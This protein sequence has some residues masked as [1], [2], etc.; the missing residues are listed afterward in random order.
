MGRE[1]GCES[2]KGFD[3]V[4]NE[5]N[6]I[7]EDLGELCEKMMKVNRMKLRM[8]FEV[9]QGAAAA[10]VVG[11]MVGIDLVVKFRLECLDPT[12]H[13]LVLSLLLLHLGKLLEEGV[14]TL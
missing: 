4:R 2:W 8:R 9:V 1:G 14:G 12:S 11:S 3:K 10:V 7:V 13:S 5:E 6:E